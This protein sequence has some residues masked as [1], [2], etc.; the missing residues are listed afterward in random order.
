MLKSL[1][2]GFLSSALGEGCRMGLPALMLDHLCIS[3][4]L[5]PDVRLHSSHL[6]PGPDV[7]SCTVGGGKEWRSRGPGARCPLTL[8]RGASLCG[9]G[10]W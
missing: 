9:Q 2:F 8:L 7:L 4:S 5:T 1:L 3:Y 6:H 10:S